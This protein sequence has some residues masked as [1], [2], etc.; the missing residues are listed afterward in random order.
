M[1]LRHIQADYK[2]EFFSKGKSK[3]KFA[4]HLKMKKGFLFFPRLTEF[5]FG[6]SRSMEFLFPRSTK[7]L[8]P[9]SANQAIKSS[10][11]TLQSMNQSIKNPKNFKIRDQ[12][13]S[14]N[15][16][17]GIPEKREKTR[18]KN[19]IPPSPQQGNED[20]FQGLVFSTNPNA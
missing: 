3:F 11:C 15:W 1:R 10:D 14:Q 19:P 18:E 13:F 12:E 7:F 5:F 16:N 6:T 4:F 8:F 20:L 2:F 17:S 9:Q